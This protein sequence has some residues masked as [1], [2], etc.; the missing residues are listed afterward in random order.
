MATAMCGSSMADAIY[1]ASTPAEHMSH[2]GWY[3]GLT[4]DHADYGRQIA[5][6][7]AW[8]AGGR[9]PEWL[10]ASPERQANLP[11]IRLEPILRAR[12]EELAPGRV[13]FHHEVVGVTQDDQRV[14]ATVIDRDTGRTHRVRA[15]YLLGCDG[16]RT[17]GRAVGI[18]Q[19]GMRDLVR[20]VSFHLSADLSR[21]ARDPEVL[22]RWLWL[23]TLGIP[24][25]LVPM[26]PDHWGPDSEEWVFHLNYGPDDGRAL[27]DESVLADLRT[28]LGLAAEQVTVH[29]ISRWVTRRRDRRPIPRR[30]RADRRRRRAP[31]PA[32]RRPRPDLGDA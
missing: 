11:Q 10:A 19:E 26:G 13:R 30:P 23:P 28:G 16:G 4:G 32:H 24:V 9:S 5:R 7:E 8:G 17:V 2:T 12:A 31:P 21:W 15:R 14:T 29:M 27:D 25:V 18:A 20:V 1:A 22:I 3:L 6:M